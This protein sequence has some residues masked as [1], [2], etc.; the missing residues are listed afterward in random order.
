M[1]IAFICGKMGWG[2]AEAVDAL[3]TS[4]NP[5]LPDTKF[6]DMFDFRWNSATNAFKQL[7]AGVFITIA[8]T[9]LDQAMMQKSLACADIKSAQKNFYSSS[10]IQVA[11]NY[12]FLILGALLCLYVD[13]LGG[14]EALGARKTDEI[15]P[16]IAS[17]QM[18][19]YAGTFFLVGLISASYP[20][21]ANALTSLTSSFCVDFLKFDTRKDI[22]EDRMKS[23]RNKIHAMFAV[24]F[25][26]I[27]IFLYVAS[28]DAVVNIVYRLVAYT[29]GPLLGFFLFGIFT[30]Y[31]IRDRAA[32]YIAA[33]SP[34][35]CLG[36]NF[37]LNE[38][39]SFDLGFT[40]LIV[41]GALAF[42]GMWLFRIKEN[43]AAKI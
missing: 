30:K 5:N 25:L 6:A 34:A 14:M 40:L 21:A 8:M 32:P 12:F 24:L 38:F 41:N 35:L 18:G 31:K 36:A 13:K 17:R 33:A 28:D 11:A 39:L 22:S 10:A 26:A 19:L 20:S 27:I 42:A 16:A 15:F 1:T 7:V 43:D 29:Y 23:V 3:A 2:I 4:A 37:A 9:G